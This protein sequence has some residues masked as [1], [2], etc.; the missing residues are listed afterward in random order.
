MHR[1]CIELP[2][3]SVHRFKGGGETHNRDLLST[4][5]PSPRITVKS[6]QLSGNLPNM[7]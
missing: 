6:V 2:S 7:R 5:E 3:H 1:H 4:L